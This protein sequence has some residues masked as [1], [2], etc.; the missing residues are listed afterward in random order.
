M[1]ERPT[2][3]P[4]LAPLFPEGEYEVDSV[5]GSGGM[6]VVYRA[7]DLRHPRKVAIKVLRSDVAQIVG[8]E[9]F[10]REIAVTSAFTHPHILPLLD[11]GE[12]KDVNG[13]SAPFYVMPLID[14]D[15]LADRLDKENRLSLQDSIRLASEILEALRYAHEHGVIHRDIKPANVLLSGGH[16]VVADFGVARPVSSVRPSTTRGKAITETGLI[17]GT[18]EYMSPEQALG[19]EVVDARCDIYAVGC[20]LYEMVVGVPPFDA[21]SPST[22]VTRKLSGEFMPATSMRNGVPPSLDDVLAKALSAEPSDRYSTATEFLQALSAVDVRTSASQQ[23]VRRTQSRRPQP[24]YMIAMAL[25]AAVALTFAVMKWRSPGIA[26]A[27]ENPESGLSDKARVAVLPMGV[28]VPDSALDLVANALTSDLIDELAR[29]PALTVISKNGV[30]SFRGGAASADSIARVLNVGS[31]VTGDIRGSGDS[32]QVTVRLV[33]GSSSAQLSSVMVAGS[34]RDVL[35][36]R[37]SIIDSV[38]SFLR[39]RIGVEIGAAERSASSAE[40]WELLARVKVLSEGPLQR[41]GT[42][43]AAERASKFAAADSL[44]D[45]AIA[46]DPRWDPPLVQRALLL[47]S[48]ANIEEQVSPRSASASTGP[49]APDTLRRAAVKVADDLLARSPDNATAFGTRGRARLALWRTSPSPTD[50]LRAAAE[51]DLRAAVSR[52]RDMAEAWNDLSQL[53]QMSGGYAQARSAAEEALRADAF[54]KNAAAVYSRVFFASLAVGRSA[55]ARDWCQRG[56]T[57]FPTDA[58]FWGCELTILGWTGDKR[59]DVAKAWTALA[60]SEARDTANF[61]AVGWGTRRL[62]VAAVAAR[63]GMSDSAVAIVARTRATHPGSA[64]SEQLDYGEA[65]VHALLGHPDQAIP[66]LEKYLRTNPALRGQVRH[67]PWFASLQRDP[68][69][70]AMTAPR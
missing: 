50:S 40:A 30:L 36:V 38:T 47:L 45:R 19:D 24:V 2:H 3:E 28:M 63:A 35:A 60:E 27:G 33:D 53:L 64:P 39:R 31:I 21:S 58:R 16:A 18:L 62:L 20:V 7:R 32:V 57:K 37:S 43:S 52:R 11:S 8:V 5:I 17:V 29:F 67:S 6:A 44:L 70:V 42:L 9:R 25:V 15:S 1:T 54:L 69:F 68:R 10:L 55:E 51:S 14:G 61:L 4:Q 59:A 56:R 66:L 46:L 34:M 13:R 65:Y 26:E 22:I 41:T 23:A 48:R 49:W 12:T